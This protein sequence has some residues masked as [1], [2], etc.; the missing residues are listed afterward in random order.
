LTSKPDKRL[1]E[2]HAE[3]EACGLKPGSEN[4]LKEERRRKVEM[5]RAAKRLE[6]CWDCGHFD[7]CEILKGHLRD[8]YKVQ[9]KS[10]S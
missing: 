7:H 9:V 2:L 8:L 5:C 6:S 4:F 3:L 1:R 10:G